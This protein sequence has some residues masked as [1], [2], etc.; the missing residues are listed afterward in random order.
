MSQMF[1]GCTL[2]NGNI[3]SWQPLTVT[4]MLGM[5]R[6]APVFNQNIGSWNVLSVTNMNTMFQNATNFNQNIGNW[7]IRNVTNFSAFMTGKTFSNYSTANYD[8]LLIGWASRPVQPNINISFGT[9]KRTIAGT[10]ARLV[11]TSPP[12]LWTIVDGGL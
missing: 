2:F 9:I 1:F 4:N 3:T 7:D 8:A 5:F 11:L 12:N 10:A 6:G